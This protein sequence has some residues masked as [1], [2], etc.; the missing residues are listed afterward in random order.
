M[1]KNN[2]YELLN[3]TEFSIDDYTIEEPTDLE[4]NKWKKS[5]RQNR[6]KKFNMKKFGAIA[7]ALVLGLGLFSQTN[8]GQKAYAKAQS[9]INGVVYSISKGFNIDNDIEPYSNVINQWVE[10]EGIEIKLTDVIIDK[11]EFI[12][13]AV[14]K[15]PEPSDGIF[16]DYDVFINGKKA[17]VP[18]AVGTSELLDDTGKLTGLTYAS[19]VENIDTSNALDIKFAFKSIDY[20]SE[21][22]KDRGPVYGDWTFAFHASG[23]ELT[24]NTKVI[25]LDVS[26][27]EE[28][29]KI[30]LEE[31]RINPVNKKIYGKIYNKGKKMWN[32]ELKGEDNL[33]NPVLFGLSSSEGDGGKIIYKYEELSSKLSN[34]ATSITLTPYVGEIPEKSGQMPKPSKVAGEP[35]T[36]NL[37]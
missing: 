32:T 25:P 9:T 7:A 6:K 18:G 8:T 26:F 33:G 1:K 29:L 37:K 15:T 10:D 30:D 13:S 28:K 20:F 35:F 3:E 23:E 2:I 17:H 36:I 24:K 14:I 5:F 22:K 31:V 4:K 21:G 16:L 19:T 12:F 27:Q 11:D 34:E